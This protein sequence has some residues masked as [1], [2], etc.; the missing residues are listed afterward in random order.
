M[1]TPTKAKKP[2]TRPLRGK[3]APRSTA[4][5]STGTRTKKK[6][7]VARKKT[8][9][10]RKPE[11]MSLEDWQIAL[12]REFG[13]AQD[14]KLKNLGDDPIFSEFTITNPQT[15]GVYRLA[16]RGEKPGDNYCS[17]PDFTVN[18]LGTCKHVEFTLARLH[19]KRGAKAA[20]ARGFHPAYSEI[21]LHYG[22]KREIVFAPGADCPENLRR[23]SSN[24]F[25]EQGYLE[26]EAFAHFDAFFRE[27]DQDGQNDH[28]LRCYE[29]AISF[30]AQVRDQA[31][32]RTLIDKAFPKGP[33]SHALARLLK[34]RL[35]HYQQEGALFAARAA[36]CLL[37]DDMGLGKT[38]Q[39]I[40]ATEILVRTVGLDRVL[41][42]CPTSLKHQWKDEI[43]KFIGRS[44]QVV[45][46]LLA[47]R[48]AHYETE[49]F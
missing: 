15:G 10:T 31:Q 16:I 13:A 17:C 49:S 11:E 21:Y 38:I 18:T 36:R 2:S 7:A 41:I 22:P 5:R 35:Y 9:R 1:A 19:R 14:F 12:R 27:A 47:A 4:H 37:A 24:Y 30:A 42:V 46:G 43:E 3:S 6:A 48:T 40:T 32:R 25:N 33:S 8:S 26:P 45:E 28:E 39:A 23:L 44:V 29:D 34:T 20:F